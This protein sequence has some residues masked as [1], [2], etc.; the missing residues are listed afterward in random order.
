MASISRT[1]IV[2]EVIPNPNIGNL[3]IWS[4]KDSSGRTVCFIEAS[5]PL[6]ECSHHFSATDHIRVNY[7]IAGEWP[8]GSTDLFDSYGYNNEYNR[9]LLHGSYNA[10]ENLAP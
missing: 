9:K 2:I 8:E 6:K 4:V 1:E 10:S 7:K 5:S 3:K